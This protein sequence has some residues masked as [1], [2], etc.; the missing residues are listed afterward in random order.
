MVQSL[1]KE[2]LHVMS[3][4]IHINSGKDDIFMIE[5]SN[6]LLKNL[7]MIKW[8]NSIFIIVTIF[9]VVIRHHCW[10][11]PKEFSESIGMITLFFSQNRGDILS[12]ADRFP[13]HYQV[14]FDNIFFN[15]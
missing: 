15:N 5:C 1:Q 11:L 12:Y 7:I 9:I 14:F 2:V 8:F 10:F 6:S 3:L 13:M 4:N